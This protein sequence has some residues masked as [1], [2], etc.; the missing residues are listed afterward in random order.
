LLYSLF[1][2]YE[3]SHYINISK[4]HREDYVTANFCLKLIQQ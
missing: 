3:W 4:T 1:Y 2:F